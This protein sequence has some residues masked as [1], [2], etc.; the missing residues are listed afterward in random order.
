MTKDN[1][2]KNRVIKA[3]AEGALRNMENL[4]TLTFVNG[5]GGFVSRGQIEI[6]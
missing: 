6:S 5:K 1:A 3:R 2:K 4:P